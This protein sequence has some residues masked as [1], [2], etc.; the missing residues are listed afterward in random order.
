[1]ARFDGRDEA[2]QTTSRIA[3]TTL[4]AL[5]I[6]CAHQLDPGKDLKC[7]PKLAAGARLG[8]GSQSE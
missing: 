8:A 6:A 1:M 2:P 7:R 5:G 3:I 4:E